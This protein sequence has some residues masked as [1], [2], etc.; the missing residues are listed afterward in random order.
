MKKEQ[1]RPKC[2]TGAYGNTAHC[3]TQRSL[4][5]GTEKVGRVFKICSKCAIIPNRYNL[6][7][8]II[9]TYIYICALKARSPKGGDARDI[10]AFASRTR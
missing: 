3:S 5:T 9:Y 10:R 2:M 1:K 8:R 7:N 4:D 6:R